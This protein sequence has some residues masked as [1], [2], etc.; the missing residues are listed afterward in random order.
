MDEVVPEVKEFI[1]NE[2][3]RRILVQ[4]MLPALVIWK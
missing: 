3:K 1:K 2:K 4:K